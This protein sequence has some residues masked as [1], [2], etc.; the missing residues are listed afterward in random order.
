MFKQSVPGNKVNLGV[1]ARYGN[2]FTGANIF[3]KSMVSD[4]TWQKFTLVCPIPATG[5]W[6]QSNDIML[7]MGASGKNCTT[8]FDDFVIEEK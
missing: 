4:G 3:R 6:G 1:Q 2:K 5:K 7:T 8:L